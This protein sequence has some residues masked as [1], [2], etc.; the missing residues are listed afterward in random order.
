MTIGAYVNT[1]GKNG[2]NEPTTQRLAI[3]VAVYA[4]QETGPLVASE[5]MLSDTHA[6]TAVHQVILL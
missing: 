6:H 5:L 1:D 2:A 4:R 3:G